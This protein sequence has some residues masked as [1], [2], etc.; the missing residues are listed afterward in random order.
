MSVST[1]SGRSWTQRLS[2]E[3]DDG[4]SRSEMRLSTASQAKAYLVSASSGVLAACRYMANHPIDFLIS[5]ASSVAMFTVL[6]LIVSSVFPLVGAGIAAAMLTS[7]ILGIG[8]TLYSEMKQR[9]YRVDA[10][11]ETYGNPKPSDLADARKIS[12]TDVIQ[13]GL[14]RAAFTGLMGGL[15]GSLIGF[16]ID[17][18]SHSGY[19]KI[20]ANGYATSYEWESYKDAL[21]GS[22]N[23]N[24]WGDHASTL[25]KVR[26]RLQFTWG[27]L[28]SIGFVDNGETATSWDEV[29]WSPLAQ[30]M[31]INS[32]D[33]FAN[34]PNAENVQRV[35]ENKW[36]VHLW[37]EAD[38]LGLDEYLGEKRIDHNGEEFT[39]DI[40]GIIG[41]SHLGG[42]GGAQ[43]FLRDGIDRCDYFDGK[44]G[45]Y[46]SEYMNKFSG[47]DLPFEKD[48]PN[49]LPFVV[50][51][52]FA[53][54]DVKNYQGID[55]IFPLPIDADYINHTDQYG[56]R[57]HPITGKPD[58][59]H[60]ADIAANIG[61]P[62]L[63]SASGTVEYTS[64]DRGIGKVVKLY[65]GEDMYGNPVYTRYGHLSDIDVR[66]GDVVYQGQEI[67]NVGNTGR[68]TGSH[69]HYEL[70]VGGR[71]ID[72]RVGMPEVAER[73]VR[74]R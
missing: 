71:T 21:G 66:K 2:T 39:V 65:H 28:D 32:I 68:S 61:L 52:N 47:H 3:R 51:Q 9:R 63:A 5:T 26:G 35:A 11:Y 64:H 22:E 57:I 50:A 59:H 53:I 62:V 36:I 24:L 7:G 1:T 25:E 67:G 10:L 60:G 55:F 14:T 56:N 18:P 48:N 49:P 43:A 27:A 70:N 46:V 37:S 30:S 58:F 41:A 69:L 8:R 31:G 19:S 20:P 33:D 45:T 72:P 6:K 40:S 38:R 74:T 54:S 15:T 12:M 17:D 13:T 16:M 42:P 34:G 4:P 29:Q 23:S 44:P 73:G